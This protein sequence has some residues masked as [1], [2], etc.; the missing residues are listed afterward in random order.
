[1]IFKREPPQLTNL[2]EQRLAKSSVALS[3]IP[4]TGD[5]TDRKM[6]QLPLIEY[7]DIIKQLKDL[8]KQ[9][10]DN[11]ARILALEKH[12]GFRSQS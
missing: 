5:T 8:K 1:M 3:S 7:L 4:K 2:S 11:Q 12:C 6:V 9:N 10:Q